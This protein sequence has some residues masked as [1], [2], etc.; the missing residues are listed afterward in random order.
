MAHHIS[1]ARSGP[2][3][4]KMN[5]AGSESWLFNSQHMW[6]LTEI[7]GLKVDHRIFACHLQIISKEFKGIETISDLHIFVCLR[8]E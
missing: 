5:I 8:K 3:Y 6:C 4:A 7:V 1:M 2:V